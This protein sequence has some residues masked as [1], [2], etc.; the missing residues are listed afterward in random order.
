MTCPELAEALQRLKVQTGSLACL[1]CGHEHNWSLHGCVILRNAVEIIDR[2]GE[3]FAEETLLKMVAQY[4]GTSPELIQKVS[5]L[6]PGAEVFVLERDDEEKACEV[7][8]YMLL[9]VVKDA[10]IVSAYIND[11]DAI[12]STL[13]YHIRETAENYDTD[14]A[15][16]PLKDC[17][18][19]SYD[20][21]T[22]LDLEN[23]PGD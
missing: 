22:A 18:S 2:M 4:L 10:V 21:H 9:A 12:E 14:L 17:Y 15:V 16:F 6:R 20:A 23:T 7:S 3:S 13:D 1:G 19:S 8:G 11:L 5:Q